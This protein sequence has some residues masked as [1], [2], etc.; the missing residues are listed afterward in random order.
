MLFFKIRIKEKSYYCKNKYLH[1]SVLI[2]VIKIIS[3]IFSLQITAT[4]V[5]LS[6]NLY[7][8]KV[9]ILGK[10]AKASTSE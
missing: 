10:K 8:T 6:L 7:T 3:N 4:K 9:Y 2:S 5:E 1:H